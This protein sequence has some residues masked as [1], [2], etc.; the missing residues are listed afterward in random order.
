MLLGAI[1]LPSP[2]TWKLRFGADPGG[3]L[4]PHA[5]RG[6]PLGSCVTR[7]CTRPHPLFVAHSRPWCV[8]T[9]SGN[10]VVANYVSRG[11]DAAD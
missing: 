10:R 1:N 5:V 4:L 7:N 2:D 8:A 9:P 6:S 3:S 11:T